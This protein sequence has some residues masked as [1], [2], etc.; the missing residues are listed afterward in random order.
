MAIKD[1]VYFEESVVDAFADDFNQRIEQPITALAFL[2]T[3]AVALLIVLMVLARLFFLAVGR[4]DFY[5]Q[6][7]LA[8]VNKRLVLPA[9][10]GLIMDRFQQPLLKNI[11]SFNLWLEVATLLK[12]ENRRRIVEVTERLAQVVAVSAAEISKKLTAADLETTNRLLVARNLTLVQVIDLKTLDLP[13]VI[14]GEDYR[15]DYQEGPVFA[16]VL[17]YTGVGATDET[18]MGVAGLEAYYD[19]VLRGQPGESIVLRDAANSTIDQKAVSEAGAGH[20]LETTLDAEFQRYFY[21]RLRSAVDTVGGKKGAGVGLAMQPRTGEI[22]ALVSLPSFD[23]NTPERYLT[24]EAQPLFNRIISGRYNPGSTIKPLVALAALKEGVVTSQWRTYSPGFLEVPNPYDAEHPHRFADWRAHG[25][26]DL[27]AAIAR[28]SNVY[29]Y[30]V[31]GGCPGCRD[32]EKKIK[33]LG[34]DRL[35]RYWQLFGLDQI[36]GI[37]LEGEAAGFLPEPQEKERRTG[38]PW[39][40]GDTYNVSIGQGDLTMTPLRL[41][42]LVAAIAND[43]IMYRPFLVRRI[44]SE[45]DGTTVKEHQPEELSDYSIWQEE[46]LEVQRGMRNAVAQP[47]GTAN[48]LYDLSYKTA[49]KTGSA[50]I[51][52]NTKTNAFFVGY[53]PYEDP[54]IAVLVLIEDAREGSLN[55]VPVARDVLQWYYDHRL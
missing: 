45:K 38:Q 26:V 5:Q 28:S 3:A 47:Y 8:N 20:R 15:R 11:P 34:I 44:V 9:Q 42:T 18:I 21:Q 49:G 29:F 2:I 35:H 27:P 4:H 24:A 16:H 23:N 46:L 10:R 19:T 1:Q 36:T 7:A 12:E 6:R 51:S 50:Q 33:G 30:L 54:Q 48:S 53:G 13:G 14:V 22:L 52:D 41:L 32:P 31:G 40:I 17:G 25:W 55:A 39:R 43:G 37:D